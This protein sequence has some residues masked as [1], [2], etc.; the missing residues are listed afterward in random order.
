MSRKSKYSY[1]QKLKAVLAVIE[2]YRSM[3]S[4][5]KEMCADKKEVSR[6][7]ALYKQFG[8][9]GLLIKNGSYSVEFKLSVIRY[10]KENDLSYFKT[11]V[12]FGIPC[13]S[14]I[15]RWNRICNEK[16]VVGIMLKNKDRNKDIS[17]KEPNQDKKTKE[18]LLKELQYLRAENAY[19]KKLQA[20]VQER[21]SRENGKK[22]KPSKN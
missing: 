13:G 12:K 16:G 21:L 11:A 7:V 6:W 9:D 1:E 22:Q 14:V 5:A 19:L 18:E 3:R 17:S 15:G 4:V 2:D 10:M 8:Q 20:L